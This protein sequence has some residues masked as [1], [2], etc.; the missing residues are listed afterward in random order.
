MSNCDGLS[1]DMRRFY[2]DI[3]TKAVRDAGG[4][5]SI[6]S[7][8]I[9]QANRDLIDALAAKITHVV[10][11]NL[12]Y[13]HLDY[14]DCEPIIAA[15]VATIRARLSAA[16]QK[17]AE[18]EKELAALRAK[19]RRQVD[20]FN[21]IAKELA[22]LRAKPTQSARELVNAF[23]NLYA[24]E[25]CV[26]CGGSGELGKS[27]DGRLISCESCGGHEDSLGRGVVINEPSLS[28]IYE[29]IAAHV[30][31]QLAPVEE[32]LARAVEV[33]R[34]AQCYCESGGCRHCEQKAAFLA[35]I[36]GNEQGG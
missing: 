28:A 9:K 25:V 3:I 15:H 6:N 29:I 13:A 35:S 11:G 24:P 32:K 19:F 18:A 21:V 33:L 23:V 30:A 12:S 5:D 2:D 31:A 22:D 14:A 17:C 8:S 34:S 26:E 4:V 1:P 27:A 16:E 20:D 10:V 7:A 36:A